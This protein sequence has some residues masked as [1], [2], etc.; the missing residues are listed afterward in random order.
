MTLL[1]LHLHGTPRIVA[2]D[3]RESAL[4]RRAAALCALAALDG[5]V[6]RERAATWLWPDSP[7]PRRNLRQQLLRFRQQFGRPLLAGE[8]RLVLADGVRLAAGEGPLLPEAPLAEGDPFAEWLALQRGRAEAG[9]DAEWRDAVARAEAAGE[10][11]AA[12]AVAERWH[13]ADPT[14]EDAAATLMRLHYLRGEAAA[15]LAVHQRLATGAAQP[16][17]AETDALAATLR[18][19]L[20]PA[21][22]PRPAPPLTVLR[23][24]RL[25]GRDPEL[26]RLRQAWR[27]GAVVVLEG[28]P[29]LGKTHLLGALAAEHPALRVQARPGDAGVPYAT[30]ARLLRQAATPAAPA[31]LPAPQRQALARVL[32]E[33]EPVTAPAG[34][35]QRLLLQQAVE[36]LLR[37]GRDRA[38]GLLLDDL[39]FADAASVELLTALL[40]GQPPALGPAVLARRPAEGA[41]AVQALADTLAEAT[42]EGGV[43]RLVPLP[44][45]PL[46][47]PAMAEL[48]RSLGL[49][50][51]DADTLAPLLVRHTGGNPLFALETL[52]QGLADGALHD[53]RLPRP[54]SV[55]TLIERRLLRLSPAALTLAR[56]AAIAGIDF[57]VALAEHVSG[58]R[59]VDLADAWAELEAAQVLRDDAFAHDLVCDAVLRTVP[60]AIARHLH[61]AV[62]ATLAAR[63]VEPA[64][65]AA[66]W[67]AAGDSA[68][69]LPALQRAADRAEAALRL[70]EALALL[71]QARELLAAAGD[72]AAEAA[73]LHRMA[74]CL[75]GH[76]DAAAQ[77]RVVE[78][79]RAIAGDDRGRAQAGLSEARL[80]FETG[81]VDEA[82]AAAQQGLRHALAAGDDELTGR[83][84]VHL[85]VMLAD[86]MQLDAAQAQLDACAAWARTAGADGRLLYHFTAGWLALSR[87]D[88]HG[89]VSHY[90]R[91]IDR[92]EQVAKVDDFAQA[93]GNLAVC[94]AGMGAMKQALVHD[95]R[96]RALV[97]QHGLAGTGTAWLEINAATLLMA[98]SRWTEALDFLERAA[99]R[100]APPDLE[101]VHLRWAGAHF[102]LGQHARALQQLDR[103]DAAPSRYAIVRLAARVLRVQVQ[104]AL[105][106]PGGDLQPLFDD[107]H[108]LADADGRAAARVR[109]W[110][111]EAEFRPPAEAWEPA[112]RAIALARERQ[113]GGLRLAGQTLLLEHALALGRL[114]EVADEV[115]L[116]LAL[117]ETY[118]SHA[119]YRGRTGLAAWRAL[120]ALGD[121]GAAP[122]LAAEQAWVRQVAARQV[123]EAFRESFLHRNPFN[124]ALLA[125]GTR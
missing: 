57:D 79:L 95:E 104:H 116:V 36:R 19:A 81:R 43:P 85:S 93:L 8:A 16:L 2:A 68:R 30:L 74:T 40:A 77:R 100:D 49:P 111:A 99:Q 6:A 61:A 84:R 120:Q 80:A 66:H 9:R 41:A 17:T 48:V 86:R 14:R 123:P 11:D 102:T 113:L 46:D 98:L 5:G 105:G 121:P 39:H 125:A 110:L 62:A 32:P 53:G 58:Q 22:A 88:F 1:T 83:L 63:D 26:G 72:R 89:G 101:M 103:A 25:V 70:G 92:P 114:D 107:A 60:P 15:G 51:L 47:V 37:H 97:V 12:L 67:L 112:R 118:E 91:C 20:R 13:A 29:G 31:A 38:P 59:A 35:A 115:P 124:R 3:G 44:L 42:T 82:I 122:L 117:R 10:L 71:E 56:V 45:A 69:A 78:R 94:Y 90:E 87:E 54:P 7:D 119:M 23:P 52:K 27:E 73:L 55:G 28:E 24:P 75:H 109:A 18:R 106:R 33:I 65:L 96:R 76:A 4:E 21:G 108:R 64:R 34:E 50:E